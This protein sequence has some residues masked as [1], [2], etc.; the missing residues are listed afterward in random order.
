MSFGTSSFPHV[1]GIENPMR[2]AWW[3]GSRLVV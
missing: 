1:V 2:S 3:M